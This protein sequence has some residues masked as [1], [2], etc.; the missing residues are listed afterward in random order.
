MRNVK[1]IR[2]F[3]QPWRVRANPHKNADALLLSDFRRSVPAPHQPVIQPEDGAVPELLK[4]SVK[5]N[6]TLAGAVFVEISTHPTRFVQ[7]CTTYWEPGISQPF[8][9]AQRLGTVQ[10]GAMV[11]ACH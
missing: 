6:S 4:L 5:L 3:Y 11:H 7:H 1:F 10:S 9:K 8:G 2:I